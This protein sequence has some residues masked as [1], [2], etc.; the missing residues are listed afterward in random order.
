MEEYKKL[1]GIYLNTE[2]KLREYIESNFKVK[3]LD[4]NSFSLA[5]D[6]K[7]DFKDARLKLQNHKY[8]KCDK[9]KY[10]DCEY[11]WIE[12]EEDYNCVYWLTDNK[13]EYDFYSNYYCYQDYIMFH[14]D[15]KYLIFKKSNQIKD[16]KID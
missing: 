8:K 7:W 1:L 16:I 12:V 2:N 6:I 15:G 14:L 4:S 11:E 9:S 3:L 5:E 10:C 13:I